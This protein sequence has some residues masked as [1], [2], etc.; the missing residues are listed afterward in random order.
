MASVSGLRSAPEASV[1]SRGSDDDV[2]YF[3]GQ[4]TFVRIRGGC[5]LA[6]AVIRRRARSRLLRGA[7][8]RRP[9]PV[10]RVLAAVNLCAALIGGLAAN[11]AGLCGPFTDVAADVFCPFVLEI[12]YL[13]ITT[14]TTP[15]TYDPAANVTRL[16]MAAFLSRTVDGAL[17]RGSRRAALNQFWAPQNETVLGLTTVG[18]GPNMPA[19]DGADVWVPNFTSSSVSRVRASEGRLLETWTGTVNP[20]AALAAMGRIFVS[21]STS[22]GKLYQID[23]SQAAGAAVLVA[24]PGNGATGL[25]F[26]GSRIWT[27]NSSGSVSIVT[28]GATI[29]WTVTTVTAGFTSDRGL[30]YDG[31]N[32]WV[33]DDSGLLK[34]DAAGAVLQTVTVGF[35]PRIP[36]FDGTNI[37]VPNLNSLNVSVVRASSGAVLAT[38][39]GNGLGAGVFAAAFDG[40]RVLITVGVVNRVSLWKA[41]DLTPLSFASTGGATGPFC[42][43][44]DGINFWVTLNGSGQ[45]ARF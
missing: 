13:G 4:R 32:I 19:S 41:A 2:S 42:V 39:T 28:P 3:D 38:L 8:M 24:T 37:W 35:A 36:A 43:S 16:Q 7:L 1:I 17:K 44:S 10:R 15:T 21:G 27:A 33:T 40:E 45:L 31:A 9:L 34:L 26:D 6:S 11:L 5:S 18:V 12:F 23:P 25:A 22:T 29:P 20:L 14:G 30:I